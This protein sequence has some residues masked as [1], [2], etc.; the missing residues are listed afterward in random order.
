MPK[1]GRHDARPVAALGVQQT[2]TV[3]R[4]ITDKGFG[5]VRG[6]DNN[7]YFFHRSNCYDG[8]WEAIVASGEWAPNRPVP[9]C[10][11][12]FEGTETQKGLRAEHVRIA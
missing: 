7:E 2:G 6:A 3:V 5:F 4:V 11:V 10:D 12:T 8:A 1:T 9:R